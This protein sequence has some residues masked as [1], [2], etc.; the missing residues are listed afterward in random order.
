MNQSIHSPYDAIAGVYDLLGWFYS[1]GAIGRAKN[2]HLPYLKQGDE[3]LY[4][5]AGT[6]AE[7]VDAAARGVQVTAI[8]SS[9]VML[10]RLGARFADTEQQATIV[11]GDVHELDGPFDAIVAPFFFNVFSRSQVEHKMACLS[12]NLRPNGLLISVDF[13]APSDSV[14]VRLIQKCYY[15]P[16]LAVFHLATGNPWHELYDYCQ[17]AQQARLPI[18]LVDTI[19]TSAFGLPLFETLIWKGR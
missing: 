13:R 2:A 5:G 4:V 7:C 18:A 19:P 11:C 1:A 9:S 6:G 10:A 3:V 14:F 17:I 16:P 8:D 12:K 15:L